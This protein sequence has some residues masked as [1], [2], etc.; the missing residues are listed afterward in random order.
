MSILIIKSYFYR[1]LFTVEKDNN[2]YGKKKTERKKGQ[3]SD[4]T[5]TVV[6]INT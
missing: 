5:R 3:K 6:C 1:L 4:T 2:L